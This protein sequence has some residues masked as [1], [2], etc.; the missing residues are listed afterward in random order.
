MLVLLFPWL[1][2]DQ[3]SLGVSSSQLGGS[4]G[5]GGNHCAM[6][7][8]YCDAG[9]DRYRYRRALTIRARVFAA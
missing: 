7:T 4:A 5:R 3:R 2:R 6:T 1:P 8:S 9:I